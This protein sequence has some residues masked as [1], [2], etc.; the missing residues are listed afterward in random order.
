MLPA[1]G[2]FLAV[3]V[4]IVL[5]FAYPDDIEWKWDE[6]WTFE[7]AQQ[8]A[9]GGAWFWLGMPSSVNLP[10]PGLSLWVFAG[11]Y[12]IFD[13]NTPPELARAVQSL[14]ATALVVFVGFAFAAIPK[15]RRE[16]WLWAAALWAVNPVEVIYERKI[17]PPSVL[18]LASVAFIAAWYF[19]R[20]AGAAFAWGLLG[21][22]MTQ[23]H[24]SAAFFALAVAAWTV[25]QDR[26]AFPWRSW[27]AGSVVGALPALPWLFEVLS[28]PG[29]TRFSVPDFSFFPRWPWQSFGFGIEPVLGRAHTLDYLSGPPL[30]GHP[31]YLMALVYVVLASVVLV[32]L[33]QAIRLI[34]SEGW[35]PARE[36]FLGT[37]PETLLITATFWGYG[38]LLTLLTL[39]GAGSHR[40]YLIVVTPI[41]ALW[42]VLAVMYGDRTVGHSRARAMLIVLCLS[43]A[44]LSDGLLSYIHR[45]AIIKGDFG[46][47]WRAQQPGFVATKP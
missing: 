9:A 46:P 5:R 38:G 19:R 17:W 41:L 22:L 45:T 15:D 42:A 23:V 26:T 20:F 11:L 24:M 8:M 32:V 30:A 43:Q 37:R 7:H 21:A 40:H 28:Q 3:A 2:L 10:N 47:T 13:A 29:G 35:P 6:N 39:F 16:P 36:V 12:W 27:L 25:V 1:L 44:V 33:L 31:T 14:N 4:G 18:P 34:R